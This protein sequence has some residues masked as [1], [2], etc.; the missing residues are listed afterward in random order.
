MLTVV[1]DIVD[2]TKLVEALPSTETERRVPV[3]VVP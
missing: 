2:K 1:Y 3:D